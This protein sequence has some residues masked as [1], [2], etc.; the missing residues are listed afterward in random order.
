M[1]GLESQ[2]TGVMGTNWPPGPSGHRLVLPRPGDAHACGV[3][4]RA[5][6]EPGAAYPGPRPPEAVGPVS[7]TAV[8]SRDGTRCDLL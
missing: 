6:V 8:T 3:P 7:T 5:G 4:A 2:A 1:G